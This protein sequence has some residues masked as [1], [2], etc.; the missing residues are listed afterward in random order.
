MYK[1]GDTVWYMGQM[2]RVLGVSLDGEYYKL[3]DCAFETLTISNV[4]KSK[5]SDRP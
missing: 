5:L 1:K 4:P 2:H 3:I